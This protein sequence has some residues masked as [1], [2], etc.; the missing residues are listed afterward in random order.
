MARTPE[1]S[2]NPTYNE[3]VSNL[4][5]TV[6]GWKGGVRPLSRAALLLALVVS[7]VSPPAWAAPFDP[8]GRD[9]EGYS[10]FVRILRS[11]VGSQ[12]LIVT[13]HLDWSTLTPADALILVYPEHGS[14]TISAGA[15]VRSGGR[16]A[17]LDDF[18][19]GDDLLT[20]FDIRRVP[21]PQHPI[22]A[23]RDNPDLAV[24]EPGA[25]EQPLT[26]G[27]DRV[28]T[29]HASG[30]S[31]PLLTTV[32]RVRAVDGADVPLA[33]SLSS[34]TGRLVALGDPSIMVNS[35]IRYPGN[36]QLAKNL[37]GYLMT[38]PNSQPANGRLFLLIHD[39][40]E[41]GTFAGTAGPE[42]ELRSLLDRVKGSLAR[43]GLPGW[44]MYWWSFI[45]AIAVLFW[46]IPRTTRTYRGAAPRFTRP[47]P[48][49]LQGGAAGH[50]AALGARHAYRG[51]AVLE[52]RRALL[53][54]LT[55]HFGLPAEASSAEVVRRVARLGGVD[56]EAIRAVERLLL[57]MAEI[58]T[59]I[60]A[61]QTHA[62]EPIRDDEVVVAGRIV[63]RI[64]AAVH[65]HPERAL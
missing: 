39:F 19:A 7:L 58:D 47:T 15:F 9:W 17:L 57:R 31:Q 50:A 46:I 62:L 60:A 23:L 38:G 1:M 42:H 51:Y 32:L 59:M 45:V 12:A 34:G 4:C 20:S 27:V 43:D 2:R 10:E 61:K 37:A 18:G 16:I 11:E 5:A 29:N 55:A 6:K 53:E 22:L 8:S 63:Q 54:D 41:V 28:V 48:M 36:R 21:L 3:I 14:D 44:V 65:R 56:A 40:G 49:S 26:H 33:L 25:T 64:L 13:H 24:A 35:M 52:W 30:L